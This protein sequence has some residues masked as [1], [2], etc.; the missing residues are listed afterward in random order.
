MK[1]VSL[2]YF[3]NFDNL[4]FIISKLQIGHDSFF[5]MYRTIHDLQTFELIIK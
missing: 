5:L 1:R 3:K 4:S 2:T